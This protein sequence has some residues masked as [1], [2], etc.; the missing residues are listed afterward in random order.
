MIYESETAI[1]THQ[2][3]DRRQESQMAAWVCASADRN[4]SIP[5]ELYYKV[6]GNKES[7]ENYIKLLYLHYDFYQ[8]I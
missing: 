5:N 2:K 7:E 1:N 3:P 4:V 6:H 8:D